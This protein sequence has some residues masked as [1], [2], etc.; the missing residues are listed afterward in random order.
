MICALAVIRDPPAITYKAASGTHKLDHT[1]EADMGASAARPYTAATS[2]NVAKV[3]IADAAE[4][5]PS[6]TGFIYIET[7]MWDQ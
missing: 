4:K 6:Y 3:K 7:N 2:S 5:I 1:R